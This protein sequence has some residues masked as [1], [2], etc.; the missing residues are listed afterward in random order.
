MAKLVVLYK[1]PKDKAAFN[2]YYKATH[3]P[4]AY[5]IPGLKKYEISDGAVSTP[6]GPSDVHL[7][8]ILTFESLAD[9]QKGLGTPEG[10]AAKVS[11]N[12]L[13]VKASAIALRRV[14]ECNAQFTPEAILVH[15]RV[16]ISVA[17]AVSEG[18]VTPVVR[19]ADQKSVL[20]IAA[21][22]RELAVRAKNKKL[23]PEEMS[24]GTFSISN[25]GMYGIDSFAAVIN[26]PEGAILAVGQVRREPVV[27]GD[28]IV[29]LTAHFRARGITGLLCHSGNVF[30]Q[31]LEGG[32]SAVNATYARILRDSRHGDVELLLYEEISERRFAGWSMGQG[33]RS[34]LNPALLLK[35][36]ERPTLDPF[37]VS[38]RVSM[39]LFDELM[40]TASIDGQS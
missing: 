30:M 12:D 17:V 2:A 14:P 40:A 29:D 11:F 16:D 25:L 8:A 26:P 36:S 38:G 20:S 28:A 22:V 10:Q 5:K 13:I 6:A 18:L 34:R 15:H 7:T 24:D 32:R 31:V 4:L 9:L 19:N 1:T 39:A 33:N 23:R 35:Y 27:K 37:A 3:I 21:E